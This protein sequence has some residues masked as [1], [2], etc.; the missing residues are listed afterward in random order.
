MEPYQIHLVIHRGKGKFR[1][2]N[3]EIKIPKGIKEEPE[4]ESMLKTLGIWNNF[5]DQTYRV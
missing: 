2:R 3:F 5:D 1:I 4:I